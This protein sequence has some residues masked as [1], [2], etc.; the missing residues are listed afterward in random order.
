MSSPSPLQAH[1]QWC[2]A[3]KRSPGAEAASGL[4]EGAR[5]GPQPEEHEGERQDDGV[6]HGVHHR[7]HEH[8]QLLGDLLAELVGLGVQ[9]L[10]PLPGRLGQP[11]QLQARAHQAPD[12]Q[13]L[14]GVAG[15]GLQADVVDEGGGGS[16]QGR[17]EQPDDGGG[18]VD[19]LLQHGDDAGR[20]GDAEENV[21]HLPRGDGR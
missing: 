2:Q 20:E 9:G 21:E 13:Q 10:P 16:G 1:L 5:A 6:D 15:Q 8:Q 18:P 3:V 12:L 4:R 11:L 19:D 14:Q 17:G 7:H